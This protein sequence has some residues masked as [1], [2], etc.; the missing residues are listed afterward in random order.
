M[1]GEQLIKHCAKAVHIR[2]A[3]DRRVVAYRLFWR[4]VTGRAQHFHRARDSALRL[5]QPCQTKIRKMRFALLIKQD[6]SR[7]DVA[8][9]N[10]VLV[11]VMN[12]ARHFGD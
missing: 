9:Q 5:D 1:R 3:C 10:V 7:F 11:S 2:R 12:G 8:M 4:H 6:I